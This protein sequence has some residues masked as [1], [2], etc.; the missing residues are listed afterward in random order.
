MIKIGKEVLYAV[1]ENP[2]YMS[3]HLMDKFEKVLRKSSPGTAL[4]EEIAALKEKYKNLVEWYDDHEGTPCEQIRHKQQVE[5][6][7]ALVTALV[8]AL[9]YCH[10]Y[11]RGTDCH[12]CNLLASSEVAKWRKA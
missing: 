9:E 3:G 12:I 10:E 4:L 11:V 6:L 2:D 5:E 8:G 7:T 1:V